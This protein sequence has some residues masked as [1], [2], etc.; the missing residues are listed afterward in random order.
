MQVSNV[1]TCNLTI[2]LQH[3]AGT[4]TMVKNI[5]GVKLYQKEKVYKA[6]ILPNNAYAE[7][8]L[9]AF[10]ESTTIEITYDCKV[11]HIIDVLDEVKGYL[12]M[13]KCIDQSTKFGSYFVNWIRSTGT[14]SADWKMLEQ[15][16]GKYAD[17]AGI[18][19][20]ETQG[21]NITTFN[22]PGPGSKT[23]NELQLLHGN[24][25][26]NVKKDIEKAIK[27]AQ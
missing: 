13:Y 8:A 20:F 21:Y 1:V 19:F 18:Y 10:K 4:E 6:P 15:V 23:A 11:Q 14:H 2:H 22:T 27:E 12:F 25:V 5:P 24:R 17:D 7:N 26:A 3:C 16:K 9:M